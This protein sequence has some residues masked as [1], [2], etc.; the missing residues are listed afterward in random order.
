[1]IDLK[2]ERELS[3]KEPVGVDDAANK[4]AQLLYGS[5]DKYGIYQLK[6]NPELNQYRFEGT[7]FL[8]QMGLLNDHYDE[9]KPENYELIYTG[10]L[11]E[12]QGDTQS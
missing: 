10:E 8:V 12:I 6:D 9:I 3:E 11:S 2:A 5:S 1:M 4:G 7:G